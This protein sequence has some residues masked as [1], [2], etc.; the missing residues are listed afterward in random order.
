M[1]HRDK[2]RA[3][4]HGLR[5]LGR[6]QPD[7]ES[8]ARAIERAR[9]AVVSTVARSSSQRRSIMSLRKVG[10]VA[11]SLL[12]VALLA[13]SLAPTRATSGLAFGQVQ[14]QVEKTKSVQYFQTRKV[15]IKGKAAPEETQTR[16][17]M[18]LGSHQMREEVKTVTAGDP[19]PDEYI[20]IQNMKTGK[21]IDLYPDKKGY[22]VPQVIFGIDL[23]GGVKKQ[24]IEAAPQVDFYKRVREFPA[25]RAQKLPDRTIGGKVAAGFQ[26]VIKTERPA[27]T[28]TWTGT[29]WVDPE[30]K[31]P[32]RIEY[33]NRGTGPMMA[34]S[35]TVRSD[36]VFDAPLDESLFSTDPPEGYRDLAPI[37]GNEGEAEKPKQ[38]SQEDKA[39]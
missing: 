32:V 39:K 34:D 35:E 17:V 9:G 1:N 13:H 18:I 23:N 24:K 12:A 7:A 4:L 27:G 5:A 21:T 33:S 37:A 25:D 26:V 28:D 15:Y 19:Q 6:M 16:K 14:E 31:L 29:Y 20:A 3:L 30:T 38:E 10:A 11:A 36:I 22:D 2:D 8:S